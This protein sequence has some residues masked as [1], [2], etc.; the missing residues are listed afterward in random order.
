MILYRARIGDQKG[1]VAYS[2]APARIFLTR[3]AASL[4]PVCTDLKLRS[5]QDWSRSLVSGRVGAPARRRVAV[6]STGHQPTPIRWGPTQAVLKE[7]P[8]S[9]ANCR[10]QESP[11]PLFVWPRFQGLRL[12][13]SSEATIAP[14]SGLGAL[15]S[16]D[17]VTACRGDACQR[18]VPSPSRA[19]TGGV[20]T[21]RIQNRHPQSLRASV[22]SRR[23]T[24][25][26]G[27]GRKPL[28]SATVP[29]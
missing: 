20:I 1:P 7:R 28:G 6:R 2:R 23:T 15:L 25:D 19:T 8:R 3:K 16:L 22:G 12:L 26:L 27:P 24:V 11:K 21:R 18:P 17:T 9:T 13:T 5:T 14:T 10:Q 4:V 29:R